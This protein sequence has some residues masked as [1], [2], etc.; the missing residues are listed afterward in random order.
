MA[1]PDLA[2]ILQFDTR[3]VPSPLCAFKSYVGNT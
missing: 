1:D 3:T 2:A